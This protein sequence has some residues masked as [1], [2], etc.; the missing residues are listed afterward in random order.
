[1]EMVLPIEWSVVIQEEFKTLTTFPPGSTE[2]CIIFQLIVL[3]K[4]LFLLLV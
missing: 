2:R 4:N 3:A 1:M